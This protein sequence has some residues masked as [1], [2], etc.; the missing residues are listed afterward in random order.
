LAASGQCDAQGK[1]WSIEQFLIV[2]ELSLGGEVR[3][4]RGALPLALMAREVGCKAIMVPSANAAEAA[5]VEGVSVLPVSHLREAVE[6]FRGQ[7]EIGEARPIPPPDPSERPLYPFDFADVKGQEGA[8]RALEVAAAGGHNVLMIGPPGSGKTMLAK[9]ILTVLPKLSFEEALEVTRIY[10]VM[11]LLDDGMGLVQRRPFRA[12]HHTISDVGLIGGGVGLPRPGEVSLAH[13]GVL[14]LDE[15]PEFRKH[16]LEV[17]RQP[18]EEAQVTISRSL[19]SLNY[20]AAVTL[21]AS[22]NPC[23]CGHLGDPKHECR[24]AP[25]QVAAYQARISGPLLDRIDLHIEVPS[26]RYRDLKEGSPGE[27]SEVIRARVQEARDLQRGRLKEHGLHCNAQMGPQ[28]LREF[29]AIDD[30]G[31]DLLEAVVDRLGMSA[32]AY[33]R[34][35]KVARTIADLEGSARIEAQHVAEAIQYR[36]LDRQSRAAA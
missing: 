7:R 8:K 9:R 23:P 6:F 34:I 13:R 29:C 26:L 31:H 15:L 10:S 5:I 19:V 35:L 3:P 36:L 21:I 27:S 12:P 11:G 33:D 32:R 16:V 2:G 4:I 22:M 28:Q 1:G 14:F 18:L 30:A 25:A 20:P 24:C 17:L